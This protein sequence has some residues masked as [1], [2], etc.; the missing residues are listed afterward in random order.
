MFHK[1][2]GHQSAPLIGPRHCARLKHHQPQH[3]EH[4]VAMPSGD[5]PA[6]DSR[7][8][9]TPNPKLGVTHIPAH[10]GSLPTPP[11]KTRHMWVSATARS[12]ALCV[13]Q[14]LYSPWVDLGGWYGCGPLAPCGAILWRLITLAATTETVADPTFE[15]APLDIHPRY[16]SCD[17]NLMLSRSSLAVTVAISSRS[18][19]TEARAY[20]SVDPSAADVVRQEKRFWGRK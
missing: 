9:Q 6:D 5:L 18:I 12:P 2:L 20:G 4:I 7:T 10:S 1:L 8:F 3:H 16:W 19:R 13:A 15:R 14:S 17:S 11:V